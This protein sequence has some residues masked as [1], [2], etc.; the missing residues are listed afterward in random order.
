MSKV[1]A[2][3][4]EVRC[5]LFKDKSSVNRSRKVRS[6]LTSIVTDL[7]E[8]NKEI[9]E[10]RDYDDKKH[11]AVV[12][13]LNAEIMRLRNQVTELGYVVDARVDSAMARNGELTQEERENTAL[14]NGINKLMKGE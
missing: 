13:S 14:L 6:R 7:N 5:L 1:L 11:K 3:I 9:G 2:L 10:E 8:A 12:D 4:T